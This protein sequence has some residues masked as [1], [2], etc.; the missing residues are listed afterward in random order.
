MPAYNKQAV[1][2]QGH[3]RVLSTKLE[4]ISLTVGWVQ[5]EL[6]GSW[7]SFK[8]TQQMSWNDKFGPIKQKKM[9]VDWVPIRAVSSFLGALCKEKFWGPWNRVSFLAA[10]KKEWFGKAY[11]QKIGKIMK[12]R[13]NLHEMQKI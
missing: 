11:K 10:L 7:L 6:S 2:E 8:I 13:N 9:M 5:A 4:N 3:T 1:A 12:M